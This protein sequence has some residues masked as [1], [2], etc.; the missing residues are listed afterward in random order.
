MSTTF[1][2]THYACMC[3]DL[4]TSAPPLL[5][6]KR[7]SLANTAGNDSSED[8]TLNPHDP[9]ANYA[10]SPLDQ[11][12]FCDE[13]NAI[14]CQRCAVE[15]IVHWYCP[16]CLFEV[17]SSAVK[18]DGNRC[19]RNCYSCPACTAVLAVTALPQGAHSGEDAYILQC[20][21]CD[22]STLDIGVQLSKP[23]KVTEQLA[24]Q[25]K[26]R[27]STKSLANGAQRLSKEEAFANLTTFYKEQ[28]SETGDPQNPYSNSP[29]SSPANLD[30]IMSL[31]GKLSA[32]AL[33]KTRQKPQ[34]M[35]EARGEKEG[36]ATYGLAD[37]AAEDSLLERMQG[38]SWDDTT[39]AEQRLSAPPNNDA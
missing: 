28:L 12:L 33:K 3:C 10:L 1:P 8:S 27:S 35:R 22:W 15:E 19:S 39:N 11:L 25:R 26:G 14:R 17:P 29:Y 6:A 37:K 30:R 21:Y 31:Y 7:A 5:S 2:Y 20:H 24:K 23:T 36:F 32:N 9:R 16:N 38:L 4:T 34:P 18:S 13:C